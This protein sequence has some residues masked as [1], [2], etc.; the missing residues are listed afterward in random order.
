MI[1]LH[2]TAG[3]PFLAKACQDKPHLGGS[4]QGASAPCTGPTPSYPG[5]KA[6]ACFRLKPVLR[7]RSVFD[8]SLAGVPPSGG[9]HQGA[10]AP[11]PTRGFMLI[12]L[13]VAAL[14]IGIGILALLGLAHVAERAAYDA[15]AET[16]A[17]LFADDVFTTLRL[18]SDRHAR[19]PD[20]GE[21]LSFWVD[22]S[23]GDLGLPLTAGGLDVWQ[24]DQNQNPMVL[25][26][27]G[28]EHSIFWRPAGPSSDS[29][30]VADIALRYRLTVALPDGTQQFDSSQTNSPPAMLLA[31]LH[32][33]HGASK[34]AAEPY[35]FFTAFSNSGSLP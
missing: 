28:G 19:S 31:T 6:L 15:E 32:V 5:L 22:V 21:W 13:A 9:S 34:M 16:R 8:H 23:E 7:H 17:A 25:I 33:W 12:E 14:V 2:S 20:Q 18:F 4:H 35:T 1:F 27:D 11:H 24:L 10:L 3:V 30:S 26:G 29:D